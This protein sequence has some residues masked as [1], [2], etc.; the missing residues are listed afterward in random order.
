MSA[1]QQTRQERAADLLEVAQGEH[2]GVFLTGPEQVSVLSDSLPATAFDGTGFEPRCLE[3]DGLVLAA[4][5]AIGRYPVKCAAMIQRLIRQ[6]E[7]PMNLTNTTDQSL[8]VW[9]ALVGTARETVRSSRTNS[10]VTKA[11]GRHLNS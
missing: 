3:A 11:P 6:Y 7:S 5:T 8:I 10:N 2:E 9:M 1:P 4:E